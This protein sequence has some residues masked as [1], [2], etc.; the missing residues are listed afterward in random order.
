MTRRSLSLLATALALTGCAG[1]PTTYLTLSAT[2]PTRADPS[3]QPVAV[4]VSRVLIPPS[5]DRTQFTT[6]TGPSTLH[7]AGNTRWAGALGSMAQITLA[8]DLAARLPATHVLMPGDPLPAAGVRQVLVNI[9]RFL[10]DQSGL[11]SLNADWTILA[12]DGQTVLAQGRFHI[13]LPGGTQ[14]GAEAATM[15]AALGRLA[16]TISSHMQVQLGHE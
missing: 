10:P 14:P 3:A 12:P 4:A 15:S 6:A 1:Q 13:N 7:V 11:V 2:P 5:I 16:D 8:R 9:Q